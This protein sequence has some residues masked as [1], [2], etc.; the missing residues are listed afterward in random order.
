V[1]QRA[2][3]LVRH[4]R[5]SEVLGT[6]VTKL[7]IDAVFTNH[8]N[9]PQTRA[10]DAAVQ[11]LLDGKRV[12]FHCFKDHV[13]FERDEVLTLAGKPYSVLTPYKNAWLKKVGSFY[14]KPYPVARYADALAPTRRR[15]VCCSISGRLS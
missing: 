7:S 2:A 15:A 5:P 12:A 8:D 13:I 11:A 1:R 14:L 3:L 4:A 10:R 6:P 9:E